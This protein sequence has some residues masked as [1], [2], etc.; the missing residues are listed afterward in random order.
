M[1]F[2]CE[3]LREPGG[4][5]DPLGA[6]NVKLTGVENLAGPGFNFPTPPPTRTL[7]SPEKAKVSKVGQSSPMS[8]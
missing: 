8:A 2:Y 1:H 5:I 3:N 4:L 6:E 7:M